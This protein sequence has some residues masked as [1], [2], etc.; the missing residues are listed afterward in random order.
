MNLEHS[1]YAF[2]F[3]S[4][5]KNIIFYWL[6]GNFTHCVPHHPYFPILS[7]WFYGHQKLY[8][9]LG[10]WQEKAAWDKEVPSISPAKCSCMSL[11]VRDTCFYVPCLLRGSLTVVGKRNLFWKFLLQAQVLAKDLLLKYYAVETSLLLH[12]HTLW[13]LLIGLDVAEPFLC[14]GG[15]TTYKVML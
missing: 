11:E 15:T 1:N 12:H 14:F 8:F 3:P 5:F 13:V 10:M 2:E 7:S 9:F 6:S 4:V